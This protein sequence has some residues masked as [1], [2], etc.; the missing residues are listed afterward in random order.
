[1]TPGFDRGELLEPALGYDGGGRV[2]AEAVAYREFRRGADE[3]NRD[4]TGLPVAWQA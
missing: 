3:G 1:L 4:G 2:T